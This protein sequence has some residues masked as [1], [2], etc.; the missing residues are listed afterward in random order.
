MENNTNNK[1]CTEGIGGK[2]AT[3]I[4]LGQTSQNTSH[5][6]KLSY[7]PILWRWCQC[8]VFWG[9][10]Q[11]WMLPLHTRMSHNLQAHALKLVPAPIC[12]IFF[13]VR[14]L[15]LAAHNKIHCSSIK[16]WTHDD[17]ALLTGDGGGGQAG[18]AGDGETQDPVQL[19]LVPVHLLLLLLPLEG[20]EPPDMW[21][22]IIRCHLLP[23]LVRGEGARGSAIRLHPGS[24]LDDGWR[25][26]SLLSEEKRLSGSEMYHFKVTLISD[27]PH[28]PL[29]HLVY[30]AQSK[31][32]A[33]I[34]RKTISFIWN[35]SVKWWAVKMTRAG[36]GIWH[37]HHE[38]T[39][40][41]TPHSLSSFSP[42]IEQPRLLPLY[43]L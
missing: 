14:S 23:R 1:T 27:R 32:R 37:D 6:Y 10:R 7:F 11:Q 5:T 36:H 20:P 24:Y 8:K 19:H 13:R 12:S 25:K 38:S 42:P 31:G 2:Y 41:L 35:K 3:G 22:A 16:F 18:V 40:T 17:V 28:W 34:V 15:F 39:L 30:F 29:F 43:S 4:H 33:K 26:G 9:I 21:G